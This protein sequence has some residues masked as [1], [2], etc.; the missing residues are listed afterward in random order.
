MHDASSRRTVKF[1]DRSSAAATPVRGA[2][3]Y[4]SACTAI[5]AAAARRPALLSLIKRDIMIRHCENHGV[6]RGAVNLPDWPALV[7]FAVPVR[8]FT[9]HAHR[10]EQSILDFRIPR[11][12]C[13]AAEHVERRRSVEISIS[14]PLVVVL[15]V[16]QQIFRA[17]FDHRIIIKSADLQRV[18]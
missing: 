17:A 16:P 2:S 7:E 10:P 1:S 4:F 8:G 13:I 15:V 5:D 14:K 18:N 11:L 6:N 9:F 12:P 3:V